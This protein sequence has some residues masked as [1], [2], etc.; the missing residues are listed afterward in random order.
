M[1]VW[2]WA[3]GAVQAASRAWL[4][5]TLVVADGPAIPDGVMV[6]DD[7]KIVAVGP[8]DAVMIPEGTEVIDVSGLTLMP[9]LVDT[10]SHIG[11][12]ALN[13]RLNPI[14][15]GLSA[16]DAFD[17]SHPSVGRARAGGITTVNVMPG[18]GSLTSGQTAYLKLRESAIVDDLLLCHPREAPLVPVDGPLRR[19]QI[20]GGMKMANGTNPQGHGADPDSRMGAAWLQ[21]KA[22]LD[23]QSAGAPSGRDLAQEGLAEVLAG[24]RTVH[25]HTH[26]SDDLITILATRREFGLDVVVH[27]GSE[28]WKVVDTLADLQVPCSLIVIDAPGGKQEALALSLDTGGILEQAGVPVAFHTDDPITDSRLLLRSA[29][30][31]VRAGMSEA[32]A[33]T[34]LTL[35]PARMLHLDHRIGSLTVGK[36]ADFI[37]LSGSPFSTWTHV[38][39][40]WVEGE[41]VFDRATPEGWA[42]ATGGEL[43]PIPAGLD[44]RPIG[45][46]RGP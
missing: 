5:A 40:T 42:L 12:S 18:S 25:Y 39:E 19:A 4:G 32:G 11:G 6:V 16:I 13:D 10:H 2:M 30:L 22:L 17:P 31:A 21:R 46:E 8:R 27:H 45:T 43:S 35:A 28:A 44:A 38:V 9:G 1:M 3:W 26:R 23:A 14:Q 37:V 33:I 20:C 7:G 29:A 34:A 15:A 36:D 41:K 24:Q